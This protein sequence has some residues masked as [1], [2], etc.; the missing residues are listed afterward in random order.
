[1]LAE[2]TPSPLWKGGMILSKTLNYHDKLGWMDY[3]RVPAYLP[4]EP[5]AVLCNQDEKMRHLIET[6]HPMKMVTVGQFKCILID[7]TFLPIELR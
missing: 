2:F 6:N 4:P 3:F 1:M 7:L 5:I